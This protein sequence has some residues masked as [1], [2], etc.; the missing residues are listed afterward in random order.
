[1][2]AKNPDI[3]VPRGALSSRKILVYCIL[4]ISRLSYRCMCLLL[5]PLCRYL[6]RYLLLQSSPR[7]LGLLVL[8]YL[9]VSQAYAA[10]QDT[11]LDKIEGQTLQVY[12]VVELGSYYIPGLVEGPDSGFFVRIMQDIERRAGVDFKLNLRPTR[13][14]Q[15][16]FREGKLVGY[17]PELH[18][19]LPLPED[20]LL[21][22]EPFWIKHI[23]V[24][25]ALKQGRRIQTVS[26]LEGLRVSVVRGYTYGKEIIHNPNIK[27]VYVDSDIQSLKMLSAGR[28]DAV[29]GDIDSTVS[30]LK[31]LK[32][33]DQVYFTPD[34][35]LY[36]LD[37]FFVFQKTPKGRML[38]E[39]V[40]QAIKVMKQDGMLKIMFPG[41]DHQ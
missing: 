40:S 19:S 32:L 7:W 31:Q 10:D 41:S 13:R 28:I 5:S 18:D 4:L 38:N 36:A 15:L 8:F 25:T 24:F 26:E 34:Q 30:A 3:L 1:M 2:E 22:S 12:S 21:I 11:A 23:H 6:S 14:T 20:Q 33:L 9:S 35:S 39:K 27:K 16:A 17:F 37:V 29:L